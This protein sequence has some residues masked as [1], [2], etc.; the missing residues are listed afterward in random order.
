M[1]I[2]YSY[3]PAQ[4]LAGNDLLVVSKNDD[5]FCTK[6]VTLSKLVEFIKGQ[7]SGGIGT[8]QAIVKF[9][10]GPNGLI[11]DSIMNE[12]ID[13]IYLDGQ[14]RIGTSA[15]TRLQI[16]NGTIES[17]TTHS[18]GG[19]V[20][21][22][23]V[24]R[25]ND[26]YIKQRSDSR[27]IIFQADNGEN[28]GSVVTYFLLDGSMADIGDDSRYTR[29]PDNSRIALGDSTN[30]GNLDFAMWYDSGTAMRS[31]GNWTMEGQNGISIKNENAGEIEIHNDL[32][33]D[34]TLRSEGDV[35]LIGSG[36]SQYFRVDS[37]LGYSVAS[38]DIQYRD[39][40]K[41]L[42][43]TGLD[44]EIYHDGNDSYIDEV[45]AGDLIIQASNDVFIRENASDLA[46]FNAQGV[47][48]YHLGTS[49]IETV[50]SGVKLP[51]AGDGIQ[52]TSP[53]GTV[54]TVTV[55]NAGNLVVT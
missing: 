15:N 19:G 1:A 3:P 46:R 12:D 10:D 9:T 48:L 51:V 35:K 37:G 26:F 38:K 14:L 27:D 23:I 30:T 50:A 20:A 29:W 24:N 31:G 41:A 54:Y 40:V 22:Q 39:D 21:T 2:I 36:F 55:D 28:D 43:G 47:K 45:G 8:T 13:K 44:L 6:S 49:K 4:S 17:D 18:A 52:L 42:F 7:P 34:L 11:G 16:F 32:N 5:Y 53:N 33:S 25:N